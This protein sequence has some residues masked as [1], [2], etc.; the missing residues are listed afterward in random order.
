MAT[1]NYKSICKTKIADLNQRLQERFPGYQNGYGDRCPLRLDFAYGGTR[2]DFVIPGGTG[3]DVMF[4][5]TTNK[6]LLQ[7]LDW[8][9]VFLLIEDKLLNLGFR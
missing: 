4:P 6:E 3:H 1:S 5:R 2:L 8:A 9:N 7:F